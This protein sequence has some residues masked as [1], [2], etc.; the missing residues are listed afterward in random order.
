MQNIFLNEAERATSSSERCRF[1]EAMNIFCINA[2]FLWADD[3][4]DKRRVMLE[5]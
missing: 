3:L 2:Q 4:K 1:I 5:V